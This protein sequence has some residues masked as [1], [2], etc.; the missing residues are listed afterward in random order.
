MYYV[1]Y[2]KLRHLATRCPWWLARHGQGA[3]A[4]VQV[5]HDGA[6]PKSEEVRE[7]RPEESRILPPRSRLHW[8]ALGPAG[9]E[10]VDD[11]SPCDVLAILDKTVDRP[12][13]TPRI[14]PR[15]R[16]R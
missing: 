14:R 8:E 10:A 7:D 1:L 15:L 12:V 16:Q 13:E 3:A 6:V 5:E 4:W 9:R 11:P 2:R